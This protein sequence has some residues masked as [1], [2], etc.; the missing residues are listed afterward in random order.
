MFLYPLLNKY[1]I[2]LTWFYSKILLY[3]IIWRDL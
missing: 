1:L 3:F 2:Y